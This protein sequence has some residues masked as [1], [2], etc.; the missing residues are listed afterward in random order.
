MLQNRRHLG[1]T[2]RDAKFVLFGQG[3]FLI[4]AN[5]KA[6]FSQRGKTAE[7]IYVNATLYQVAEFSEP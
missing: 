3:Y 5:L 6:S 1:K 7:A 2:E 4:N